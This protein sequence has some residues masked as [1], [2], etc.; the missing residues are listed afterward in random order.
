VG[1]EGSQLANGFVCMKDGG[2]MLV[3]QPPF[4]FNNIYKDVC[5]AMQVKYGFVVGDA[6]DGGFTIDSGAVEAML[7]KF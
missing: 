3:L 7:A 2:S 5:D 4:R 6:K 1:V